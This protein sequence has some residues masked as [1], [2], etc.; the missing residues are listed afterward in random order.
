MNKDT[1]NIAIIGKTGVGKSSFCNYVFG[2]ELFATGTGKPVTGWERHFKSSVVDY[3]Q[4]KLRLFDSV[5]IEADNLYEWKKRLV[6]FINER[7]PKSKKT[8]KDWVHSMVYV[9]NANS[10]RVEE[11][12]LILIEEIFRSGIPVHVVMTNCDVASPEKKNSIREII[13]TK[14]DSINV[15]E[16]CSVTIRRRG[17]FSKAYGKEEF[18]ER[19]ISGIDA[20]LKKEIFNYVCD[21][22][23]DFFKKI[24]VDLGRKIDKSE[25]GFWNFLIG[26]IREGDSFDMESLL[27]IGDLESMFLEYEGLVDSIDYFVAGLSGFSNEEKTTREEIEDLRD[28]INKKIDDCSEAIEFELNKKTE[29][30]ESDS[31]KENIKSILSMGAVLINMKSFFKEVSFTMIESV[32]LELNSIRK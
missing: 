29:G 26:F 9:F 1:I 7:S 22:S 8:P 17:G 21:L 23:I 27:D 5:G 10:G 13:K 20:S 15:V 11:N 32:I 19:L 14:F 2:E 28:A 18:I 30:L 6:E 4:F 25:L 3:D 24:K 16:V 12:E 31:I